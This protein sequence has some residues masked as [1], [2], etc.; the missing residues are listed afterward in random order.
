MRCPPYPQK[1]ETPMVS[2]GNV[3]VDLSAHAVFRVYHGRKVR[4]RLTP[5]E[6]KVL[7]DPWCATPDGS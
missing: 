1:T 6:W 5:T 4:V 7:G 3:T 2:F